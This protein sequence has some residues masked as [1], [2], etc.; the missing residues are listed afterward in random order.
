MSDW[1]AE[2]VDYVQAIT[3]TKLVLGHRYAQWSLAGP[4][5]EDDIGG[6]SAAQEEVGHVRQLFRKLEAQGRDGDWLR[7]D[8]ESEEFSNASCLD[9]IDGDWTA[10]M[11]T[12]APVDRAAWYMLDAID[13]DDMDGMITKMGEDEYFH[14]EYHDARLETLAAEDAETL[15]ST[16]A[17]TLPSALALIGPKRLDDDV[18]PLVETGFTSQSVADMRS[19]F[20]D[21]YRDLFADTAVSLEGVDWEAPDADAWDETRRRVGSGGIRSEDLVQIRGERNAEFAIE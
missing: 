14:L 17:E 1:S 12:I 11:A 15:E 21:H 6:S 18:D 20:I 7:G 19:R 2:A 9:A 13:R 3:D 5:L 10:Y 16:L 4:S 8:R